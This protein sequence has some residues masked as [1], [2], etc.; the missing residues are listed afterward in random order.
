[1]AKPPVPAWSRDTTKQGLTKPRQNSS[2]PINLSLSEDERSSN[3]SSTEVASPQLGKAQAA[4]GQVAVSSPP[5]EADPLYE[6]FPLSVDDWSVPPYPVFCPVPWSPFFLAPSNLH[7]PR[8]TNWQIAGCRPSMLYTGHTWCITPLCRPKSRHH[9]SR[10][11][12]NG[13]LP[14]TEIDR[15]GVVV[16]VYSNPAALIH[17]CMRGEI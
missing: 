8:V 1:M 7:K 10:S 14:P 16:V 12:R 9:K 6:Y 17:V 13:T 3:R 4:A 5:E 2:A 15:G 11:S